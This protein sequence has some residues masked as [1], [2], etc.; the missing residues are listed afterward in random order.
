MGSVRH[1]H[2]PFARIVLESKPPSLRPSPMRTRTS[3]EAPKLSEAA[4]ALHREIPHLG[5]VP[6]ERAER[7]EIRVVPEEPAHAGRRRAL[8]GAGYRSGICRGV[9][10][11]AR[12]IGHIRAVSPSGWLTECRA[13]FARRRGYR[14]PV[15]TVSWY[16]SVVAARRDS[17]VSAAPERIQ[18][19]RWHA[20]IGNDRS[21]Y[22]E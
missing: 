11:A 10:G 15:S 14:P 8:D 16:A 1:R 18:A 5:V 19:D 22:A 21:S 12:T 7:R 2:Q 6:C 3:V 9:A 13:F 17:A 4:I 20:E